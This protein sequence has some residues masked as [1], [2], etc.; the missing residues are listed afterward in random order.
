MTKTASA[1]FEREYLVLMTELLPPLALS[2]LMAVLIGRAW[3]SL[4]K[5]RRD[6]AAAWEQVRRSE[7]LLGEWSAAMDATDRAV[8]LHTADGPASSGQRTE[9]P[10][11][12]PSA[13][14]SF[15]WS[16]RADRRWSIRQ[17]GSYQELLSAPYHGR[18]AP[19]LR[20]QAMA[21][22]L[23]ALWEGE[24]SESQRHHDLDAATAEGD[25]RDFLL[26]LRSESP[27]QKSMLNWPSARL[28]IGH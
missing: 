11:V 17:L 6:S 8:T 19:S 23:E 25:L 5:A 7:D 15:R 20:H 13:W 27:E 4:A 12:Q 22:Y 24:I 10:G 28:P 1:T 9:S 14:L 18:V 16:Q 21:A 2:F 26:C 3:K